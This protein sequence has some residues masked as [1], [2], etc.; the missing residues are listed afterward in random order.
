MH[1]SRQ[2]RKYLR[3]IYDILSATLKNSIKILYLRKA[4][5]THYT[6]QV[7]EF[8]KNEDINHELVNIDGKKILSSNRLDVVCRYL[9]FKDIIN[10]RLDPENESLYART[11]LS[12]TGASEPTHFFSVD[13]KEG[14]D[15]HIAIA[16]D[17][18]KDILDNGFKRE[19]YIPVAKDLS[20]FNGAHRLAASMAL[21][22]NV[23]VR[24]FDEIGIKDFNF[25]WFY[26]NG[27]SFNDKIKVLRGFADLYQG[28]LGIY[29]LYGPCKEQWDYMQTQIAKKFKIV[30]FVDLDL[31]HNYLAF[32]NLIK[33]I[34][35]DYS[36]QGVIA[37]KIHLLKFSPLIIRIILVSDEDALISDFNNEMRNV[38]NSIRNMISF[39]LDKDAFLTLHGSE[40]KKEFVL[41]KNI[42][43]SSNNIKYLQKRI[44]STYRTEFLDWLTE[45]KEY[46]LSNNINIED[47]CI[48]GSSPLE[49]V[50]IRNSTDIDF[51]ISSVLRNKYG[52]EVSHLSKHLDIVT[53]CYVRSM[54][55]VLISDDELIYNDKYH[56]IFF[57]CKF[58]NID[59]VY[60]RKKS[61]TREKDIKDV[62]LIE[63]YNDFSRYLDDRSILQQQIAKQLIKRKW[64][65]VK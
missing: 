25:E 28:N 49:V 16:K 58:A 2:I 21:D 40:T 51:T 27:F 34:Y 38:K 47:T 54:D 3:K 45:F 52:D 65:G 26:E 63:L 50:G 24:Y 29:T 11:I 56:F 10:E 9:F 5:N 39:N 60:Y 46:C 36:N 6:N 7:E 48:V 30:G 31:S 1:Y 18:L 20:L 33:D 43:L 44:Y 22:E 12:R 14:I 17:L 57:G 32:E 61:G 35:N 62:R 15:S 19:Y 64:R 37:E 4:K 55:S 59:L 42:L 8:Y 41:L 13:I 53:R 23:W